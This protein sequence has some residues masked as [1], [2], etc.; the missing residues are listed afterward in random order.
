LASIRA[1]LDD[2]PI[3]PAGKGLMNTL[4][5]IPWFSPDPLVLELGGRAITIFPYRVAVGTAFIVIVTVSVLF[6]H[7]RGRSV[8]QTLDLAIIGALFALPFALLFD[9]LQNKRQTLELVLSDPSR[10]S[11]LTLHW[12]SYGGMIGGFIGAMIWK[13]RSKASLLEIG[14]S[15][16]FALP[17][18]MIFARLGC[19]SAHDHPGRVS[20]FAL[21]V[22]DFQTGPPPFQP[23]HDLGLYEAIAAAGV[24]ALLLLL[25]RSPRKPG[26]YVG[27]VAI[28]SPSLRFLLD[29][30]RATEAEG[31][32]ARY[33]GLTLGQY[34]APVIVIF[35]V[36]ITRY[37]RAS[38]AENK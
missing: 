21:A 18:G 15:F 8:Q 3:E 36:V 11:D 28:L 2:S 35:G 30:L 34:V 6:A 1:R 4:L 26:F 37:V 9:I 22:A 10:I 23:R 24:A 12:S 5:L 17:F 27:L 14:D 19:F 38:A 20:N 33:L 13:W 25:S 32:D 29:F 31:G 16:A 7:K